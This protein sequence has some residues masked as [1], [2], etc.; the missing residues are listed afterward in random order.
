MGY[1][2]HFEAALETLGLKCPRFSYESRTQV[3]EGRLLALAYPDIVEGEAS[4]IALDPSRPALERAYATILLGVLA[5]AGRGGAERCLVQVVAAEDLV[6][7]EY[8]L[9]QLSDADGT[10]RHRGIYLQKSMADSAAGV[11]GLSRWPDAPHGA[12]LR[13][14]VARS[15]ADPA[16]AGLV[17]MDAKYALARHELLL[18]SD[19]QAK[20]HEALSN[21]EFRNGNETRW[22]LQAGRIRGLPSMADSLRRRLDDNVRDAK[23]YYAEKAGR[24]AGA[25][26]ERDFLTQGTVEGIADLYHDD[27]LVALSELGAPLSDLEKKRLRRFGYACDPGE[28]LAELLAEKR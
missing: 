17:F 24:A 16:S 6:P 26:F 14:L 9:T 27:L 8:A 13:D 11:R 2:K 22:A 20:L 5:K 25:H 7:S 28:R 15:E 12:F 21:V 10:G 3:M 4:R 23:E 18:A 1:A 19:W